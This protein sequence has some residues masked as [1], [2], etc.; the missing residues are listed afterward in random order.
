MFSSYASYL[1]VNVKYYLVNVS[2]EN[3]IFYI[4]IPTKTIVE[5]LELQRVDL[6]D[7][8]LRD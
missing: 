7:D 8:V 4:S 6:R 5:Y 2:V 1:P 3:N